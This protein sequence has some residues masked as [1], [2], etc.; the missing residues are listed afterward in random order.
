VSASYTLTADPTQENP[1]FSG[2]IASSAEEGGLVTLGV[3]VSARD[4]NN[5]DISVTISGLAGDLSNFNG[6]SYDSST[7]SWTGTGG[8]FNTLT[9][10][11]GEDGVQNLTI[12]AT[13]SGA[14]GG[15]SNESYTLTVNESEPRPTISV[16]LSGNGLRGSPLT[17]TPTITDADQSE[18]G[19][20]TTTYRWFLNAN[21]VQTH[22]VSGGTPDTFTGSTVVGPLVVAAVYTDKEGND[23]EGAVLVSGPD[24]LPRLL[25][26]EGAT[27]VDITGLLPD[28]TIT[29]VGT[30]GGLVGTFTYSDNS[31]ADPKYFQVIEVDG[32]VYLTVGQNLPSD[33]GVSAPDVFFN[34]YLNGSTSALGA[35]IKPVDA[36]NKTSMNLTDPEIGPYTGSY[37]N[38]MSQGAPA[39]ITLA[40]DTEV[41][42]KDIIRYQSIAQSSSVKPDTINNFSAGEGGDVIDIEEITKEI[43]GANT[44]FF[45]NGGTTAPNNVAADTLYFYYKASSNQTIIYVNNTSGPLPVGSPALMQINLAGNFATATESP[46]LILANFI[47]GEFETIEPPLLEAKGPAPLR[48]NGSVTLPISVAFDDDDSVLV[49]IFGL[50]SG[51]TLTD[52]F[53]HK[54]FSGNSIVLTAAQVNSGLSL[55]STGRFAD[56]TLT[57]AGGNSTGTLAV[58]TFTLALIDTYAPPVVAPIQPSFTLSYTHSTAASTLFTVYERD[59]TPITQYD[60]WDDGSGGGHWSINGVAKGSNQEIV[61]NASQLSQVTYTPGAGTDTLYVR[62]NDGIQWGA[63]TIPGFTATEAAPVSSPVHSFVSGAGGKTY[64]FSE[65]FTVS[66]ADGDSVAVYDFWDTGTGGGHWSVNGVA[67]GSNQEILVNTSQ[68]SQVTYQAGSGTDTIYMRATDGLHF[69]AWTPGV[70]V[71]NAPVASPIQSAFTLSHT[72][73][74]AATTLFTATDADGDPIIQYDFWD[75]G[76]GGGHWSVN[77]VAQGSNQ[78]IVVNALQLSQVTYTP[79]PAPTR[80]ICA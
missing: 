67:Q 31:P 20:G 13:T 26:A 22:T 8:E 72:Q 30:P 80:C 3:T 63:W 19:L 59:G 36:A 4:S 32:H 23:A 10:S 56:S 68:L 50:P 71:A 15:S 53:D 45:V 34:F 1:S 49:G 55:S 27:S 2:A 12:T 41:S 43:S 79:E 5:G 74:V 77:G 25:V 76:A 52:A 44:L 21:L 11:A 14:E 54:T 29:G 18:L 51:V 69:G 38:G 64:A 17:A 6:G 42:D 65:L 66:D 35:Y 47:I 58:S 75:N 16:S 61:V 39:T 48:P 37:L 46:N 40:P 78:E 70:T 57:V 28:G 9:F 73:S 60:F 7:G 62:A 24:F 33:D